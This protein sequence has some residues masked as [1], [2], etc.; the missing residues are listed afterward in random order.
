MVIVFCGFILTRYGYFDMSNQKW[1]SRINMVFFTPCLLFSNIAS[2]ISMEKLIGY[3]PIPFFFVV[4]QSLSWILSQIGTRLLRIEPG[5]RPFVL[6]CVMFCNTN[7][8]PIAVISSLAVSEAGKILYWDADDTQEAVAARGISYVLFFAMFCN[9]IRWSYGYNLLQP[10]EGQ[11]DDVVAEYSNE[12]NSSHGDYGSM[13]RKPSGS[14]S[15]DLEQ[16][17]A[18]HGSNSTLTET[19]S[20]ESSGKPTKHHKNNNGPTNETSSLLSSFPTLP[21]DEPEQPR[22]HFLSKMPGYQTVVTILVYINSYMSPPMYAASLALVVGLIPPLK[23]LM[24]ASESFLYPSVTKA[25]ESCG[26]AA[27]PII[28]VCLGAQV[29]CIQQGDHPFPPSMKKPVFSAILIRMIVAPL[30]VIPI[31]TAFAYY[32]RQWSSLAEDPLFIV[33]M[34]IVGCTPTAINLSQITQ[35]SGMFEEEMLHVLSWSYG[36]VCVPVCTTIVFLALRIVDSID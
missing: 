4:F 11:R 15:S 7:S 29:T 26:K 31:V 33:T 18:T 9:L 25:I 24:Y 23:H 10:P 34:I 3:W 6:A 19:S 8:L 20:N 17:I 12:D 32:G 16:G 28:L 2:V 21:H 14:S 36:V 1:L 13:T 5:Y 35:V 22:R 30:F 27:V